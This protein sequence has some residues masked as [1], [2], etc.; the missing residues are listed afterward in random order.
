VKNRTLAVFG[1]SFNPPHIAHVLAAAYVLTM[2]N[3]VDGLWIVPVFQHPFA[4]PLA[5]FEDRMLMCELAFGWLPKVKVSSVEQQLGGESRT[6]RTVRCL[7]DQ[8]PDTQFRLV[9]GSD[10]LEEA[11]RWVAFEELSRLAPPIVLGRRGWSGSDR[12]PGLFPEIS[13][14]QIRQ[15]LQQGNLSD[16]RKWVPPTVLRHIEA[17]GLYAAEASR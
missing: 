5:P 15:A 16:V 8:Y 4:K 14:S 17:R 12:G 13:S 2:E 11:P 7:K 6:I 3:E 1:G 10:I 9:Y